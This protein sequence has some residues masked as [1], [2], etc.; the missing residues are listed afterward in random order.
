MWQLL[1]RFLRGTGELHWLFLCLFSLI[2]LL[3]HDFLF[4]IVLHVLVFILLAFI[5]FFAIAFLLH[6]QDLLDNLFRVH[7]HLLRHLQDLRV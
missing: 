4:F 6:L 3:L 7:A 2:L 5:V 1:R